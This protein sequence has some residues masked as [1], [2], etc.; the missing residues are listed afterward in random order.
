MLGNWVAKDV[1]GDE[2]FVLPTPQIARYLKV[3]SRSHHRSEFYCTLS[4]IR[5]FGNP[6]STDDFLESWDGLANED[7]AVEA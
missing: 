6:F 4:N 7:G 1:Q 5:V 2:E 3:R